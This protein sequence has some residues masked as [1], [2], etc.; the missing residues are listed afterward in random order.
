MAAP[1][2]TNFSSTISGLSTDFYEITM[3]YSYWKH[4]RHEDE[5]VFEISF[6]KY[7]YKGN[8]AIF[9]GLVECLDFISS[10]S[11][12]KDDIDYL[13]RVMPPYIENEF[14]SYLQSLNTAALNLFFVPEG[15]LIHP[16][17]P[18]GI[19]RGPLGLIQLLETSVINAIDYSTL[20]STK[21]SR[22]RLRCPDKRLIEGGYRRAP[23]PN[24]GL[25][26][27]R[28]AYL[29]G[30]D[31]TSNL[32][33][34]KL[35][36]IPTRGTMSHAY[37]SAHTGMDISSV[38]RCLLISKDS[39]QQVHLVNRSMFYL[40]KIK[41]VCGL[42][43]N[44]KTNFSELLSFIAF[45]YSFPS[46]FLPVIDT[47]NVN[48]SG[49]PNFLAVCLAL[50]EAG[51]RAVGVRIDSGD[52]FTL[53][54]HIRDVFTKTAVLFQ[55]SWV[56]TLMVVASGDLE[57][58]A[59][60]SLEDRKTN[61]GA[62]LVGTRL[63]H[64]EGQ[65]G[66]GIV[67]KLVQKGPQPCFKRSETMD[68]S[69]IPG[70]KSV[71]RLT[72]STGL[73]TADYLCLPQ[74]AR[75][76]IRTP[77]PCVRLPNCE[78][79]QVVPFE[80]TNLLKRFMPQA[81]G[82]PAPKLTRDQ[83]TMNLSVVENNIH[84]TLLSPALFALT[85][86]MTDEV[87][88]L[89][90]R[91][92]RDIIK[93]IGSLSPPVQENYKL[94]QEENARLTETI[95]SLEESI[96]QLRCDKL[97]IESVVSELMYSVEQD[98]ASIIARLASL[99]TI[100]SDSDISSSEGS[101]LERK[102]SLELKIEE[103]EECLL[104][105]ERG[106][107]EWANEH[108]KL[109]NA[110]NQLSARLQECE[111]EIV[112]KDKIIIER[113][114]DINTMLREPTYTTHVCQ[115][116]TLNYSTRSI[117]SQ[118]IQQLVKQYPPLRHVST[119][120]TLLTTTHTP[121]KLKNSSEVRSLQ[122]RIA[123]L[124][125][126]VE[127]VTDTR[128]HLKSCLE[129]E[130]ERVSVLETQLS[131]NIYKLKV[132]QAE[133]NSLTSEVLILRQANTTL[134]ETI[135]SGLE[136]KES[137]NSAI[138]SRLEARLK[139]SSDECSRQAS[140]LYRLNRDLQEKKSQLDSMT[141]SGLRKDKEYK[142][143]LAQ[144]RHL[145]EDMREQTQKMKSTIQSNEE[146]IRKQT[147][148]IRRLT[149]ANSSINNKSGLIKE[150]LA[151]AYE[152]RDSCTHELEQ[153][154]IALLS[155]TQQL[156]QSQTECSRKLQLLRAAKTQIDHLSDL[157]GGEDNTDLEEQLAYVTTSVDEYKRTIICIS[158]LVWCKKY[159]KSGSG[160]ER[161]ILSLSAQEMLE[162]AKQG[163]TTVSPVWKESNLY[164]Q[165]VSLLEKPPPFALRIVELIIRILDL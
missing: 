59:I 33:A 46:S 4:D 19:I 89:E 56:R 5:A 64:T 16:R 41:S 52:L 58:E 100:N 98:R 18:I 36:N 114:N 108:Q 1:N 31:S 48:H 66:L 20:V 101:P 21:A 86:K 129:D 9:T 162:V 160:H 24:G 130:Q 116:D 71:Y 45:S 154:N 148:E 23:G 60:K 7:P 34:G 68:K 156:N 12:Q 95:T 159:N 85:R 76:S 49:L 28:A 113:E 6:R 158:E 122:K 92:S 127:V 61:I 65:C 74:E 40:D 22:I 2:S 72:F 104:D 42:L 164:V 97:H 63:V 102:Y 126:Q 69:V 3:C 32:L 134:Q 44:S 143:N 29:G 17:V 125:R 94:S 144:K 120:T 141:E 91:Y 10:F 149:D 99:H 8:F 107:K 110:Y 150:Q 128:S 140:T 37:I 163:A 105:L 131:E 39:P 53:A 35:Y 155:H 121:S 139:S 38:E 67:F 26:A 55:I 112:R 117:S 88:A 161:D 90:L 145:L 119:Q 151:R 75:P 82:L 70:E 115:T 15:T 51:Y 27:S 153:A 47:Y 147:T 165:I 103:L 13:K 118:T 157:F 79:V 132:S 80:V 96:D 93:N 133:Y 25:T 83:I 136:D 62:Y 142:Q 109:V 137:E 14:F 138:F 11:F 81:Y 50:A 54:E 87:N 43:P 57:E 106:R 84:Q 146:L 152:E 77:L 30:F 135:Q 78:E 123:S 73:G 111:M 124:N